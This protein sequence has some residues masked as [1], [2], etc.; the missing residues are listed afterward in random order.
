MR[1][2]K[3]KTRCEKQQLPKFEEVCRTYDEL[4][5]ASAQ[6]LSNNDEIVSIRCNVFI[7]GLEADGDYM[8]DFL[9]TKTNGDLMV[10]EAVYR[11]YLLKPM[12]AK[13]LE[14]SRQY[15]LRHGVLDWGLMIDED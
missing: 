1:S 4:Q 3:Q 15:W 5:K 12:T 13:L 8:T 9:C 14:Q 6:V 2:R 10:R 7:D 11:K